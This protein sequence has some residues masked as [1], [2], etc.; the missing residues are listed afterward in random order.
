MSGSGALCSIAPYW[1]AR[2]C[3]VRGQLTWAA[4][5]QIP[6]SFWPARPTAHAGHGGCFSIRFQ[7]R[8]AG[9]P[10]RLQRQD[11]ARGHGK[12]RQGSASAT[13]ARRRT[14]CRH[15]RP[16]GRA[17]WR[18]APCTQ[19]PDRT[20]EAFLRR[21]ARIEAALADP[22]VHARRMA[23]FL[24]KPEAPPKPPS[25][26]K[27][28]PRPPSFRI[29]EGERGPARVCR[30]RMRPAWCLRL[31][32]EVERQDVERPSQHILYEA[33]VT[34]VLPVEIAGHG[35]DCA[36]ADPVDEFCDHGGHAGEQ[37]IG[38]RI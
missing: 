12:P 33:E 14:P 30:A 23:F 18:S 10:A 36:A 2:R 16:A 32:R 35:E 1:A 17:A 20:T 3:T 38:R 37:G 8:L 31:N 11:A 26:S 27:G 22:F 13:S 28:Q 25:R 7:M 21:I 19:K 34:V 6:P 4:G 24:A 9:R 29:S 5:R 15:R